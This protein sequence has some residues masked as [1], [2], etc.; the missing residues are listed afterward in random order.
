MLG[1]LRTLCRAASWCYAASTLRAWGLGWPVGRGLLVLLA[2]HCSLCVWFFVFVFQFFT[3]DT[4]KIF[5][6]E[7]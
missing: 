3:F 6:A 1:P 2:Q 7:R 4:V 5:R